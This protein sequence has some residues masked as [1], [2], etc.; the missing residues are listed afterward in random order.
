MNIIT[1]AQAKAWGLKRYFLGSK[2]SKGHVA[3]R[4]VSN[5]ACVVCNKVYKSEWQRSLVRGVSPSQIFSMLTQ[6][7]ITFLSERYH[8]LHGEEQQ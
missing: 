3:E 6:E 7:Q 4:F 5:A 2:C 8:K 1:R